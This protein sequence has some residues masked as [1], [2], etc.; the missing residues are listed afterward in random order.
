MTTKNPDDKGFRGLTSQPPDEW[1]LKVQ[2]SGHSE[3]AACLQVI[4]IGPKNTSVRQ[5]VLFEHLGQ[6]NLKLEDD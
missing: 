5:R 2:T 1:S 4:D 6:L 3:T